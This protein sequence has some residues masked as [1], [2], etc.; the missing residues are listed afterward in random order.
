MKKLEKVKA[1]IFKFDKSQV[2]YKEGEDGIIT[3][4]SLTEKR[5]K[6]KQL[7]SEFELGSVD[8]KHIHLPP[9]PTSLADNY[10]YIK[11]IFI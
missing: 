2:G 10:S 3:I 4:L 5:Q 8:L 1:T 7:L 9:E 6:K 11:Y